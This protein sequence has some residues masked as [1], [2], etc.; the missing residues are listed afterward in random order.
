MLLSSLPLKDIFRKL[1]IYGLIAGATFLLSTY[2]FCPFIWSKPEMLW[3]WLSFSS[4]QLTQGK[5]IEFWF[6]EITIT[7]WYYYIVMLVVCIPPATLLA[8]GAWHKGLL[9]RLSKQPGELAIFCMFW[10]AVINASLGLRQIML[11]YM[12]LAMPSLCLGA[13]AGLW[14]IKTW[15]NNV[16]PR[17]LGTMPGWILVCVVIIMECYACWTVKPYYMEYFNIFSG[18]GASITAN[19]RF[20]QST[21]CDAMNPLF[22]Y[23]R[24]H[25][26]R[27]STVLCKV[28]AWPGIFTM[29]KR[30]GPDFPLQGNQK[31]DPL[32]ARY[33]LRIGAERDNL[34]YR[35]VPDPEI[36]EKKMDVLAGTLSV[37]DVWERR[38]SVALSGLIYYDDFS[39]PQVTHYIAGAQNMNINIF[40]AGRL[41]SLKA[42]EPAGVLIRIPPAFLGNAQ[43]GRLELDVKMQHGQGRIMTGPAPEKVSQVGAYS[44]Q[45]G[46]VKSREF[47]IS[48]QT[49]LF[50]LLEWVSS[51]SWSGNP[52]TFW[53]ADC[54]DSLKIYRVK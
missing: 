36:Y 43:K 32:G 8:F 48:A 13:A 24:E 11:H 46:I 44:Y 51:Y 21:Y 53:E 16:V 29:Q 22:D 12:Q 34:F 37:G 54:L 15:L 31:V 27:P 23:L 14:R 20:T 52:I 39:S 5:A 19:Q 33:V 6:G 40:S 28:A 50:V 30:L 47:D 38:D 45:S 35:Y 25:G 10:I 41:Y 26:K 4:T 17:N 2:L 42:G 49:N 7:P 1:M 18:G 3:K 9:R